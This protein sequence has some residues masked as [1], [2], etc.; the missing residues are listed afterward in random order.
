[1]KK[2]ILFYLLS[3]NVLFLFGQKRNSTWMMGGYGQD[4]MGISFNS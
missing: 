4:N 3:F 1:M 2:I